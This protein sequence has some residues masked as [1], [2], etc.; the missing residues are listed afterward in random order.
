MNRDDELVRYTMI[1]D[2]R[3]RAPI[4]IAEIGSS[5]ARLEWNHEAL[6]YQ[7]WNFD[8]WCAAANQA[9][10]THIKAQM[11]R[12]DHFPPEEQAAKR[13]LEFPRERLPEFVRMAHDYGLKAGMSVFDNDAVWLAAHI[14]DFIKLAAREQENDRLTQAAFDAC[15]NNQRPIYRSVSRLG[16]MRPTYPAPPGFIALFALQSY[17]APM[18]SSLY[19]LLRMRGLNRNYW[20]WSSHTN[21]ILDC[22]LAAKLGA[23]VIEKHLRLSPGDAEAGW[24]LPV[25]EFRRMAERIGMMA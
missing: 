25:A 3:P 12:A 20:G 24:S 6:T 14:C 7:N 1:R 13:P 8:K 18:L 10:A 4:L 16:Y 23:S 11:F 21:G 5:P 2:A 17:P 19:W 9:D 15:W 22:V